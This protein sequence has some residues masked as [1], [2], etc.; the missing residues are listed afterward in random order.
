MTNT[1]YWLDNWQMNSLFIIFSFLRSSAKYSLVAFA[2]HLLKNLTFWFL[3]KVYLFSDIVPSFH[4]LVSHIHLNWY[5][6]CRYC[7]TLPLK[8]KWYLFGKLLLTSIST[9]VLIS[10]SSFDQHINKSTQLTS[11]ST[12]ATASYSFCHNFC[13]Q[14]VSFHIIFHID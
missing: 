2:V 7:W 6:S 5:V 10:T 14:L 1:K 4:T 11:I 9:K 12:I 3:C 8:L 13:V